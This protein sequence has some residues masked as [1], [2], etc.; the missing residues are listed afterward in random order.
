MPL[1]AGLFLLPF[2]LIVLTAGLTVWAHVYKAASAD[3][4]DSLRY[5]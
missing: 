2:G 3:P 1:T 4:I 5:E